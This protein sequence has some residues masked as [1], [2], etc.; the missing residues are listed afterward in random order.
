ML[1]SHVSSFQPQGSSTV[2]CGYADCDVVEDTGSF[3]LWRVSR[4]FMLLE[5]LFMLSGW[6]I[7]PD[8][9]LN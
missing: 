7:R 6:S 1:R 8:N 3:L 9:D 4:I 5:G 2:V